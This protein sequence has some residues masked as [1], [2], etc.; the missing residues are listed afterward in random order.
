MLT[1]RGTIN[2]TSGARF[3]D[4]V[5]R[6]GTLY[7]AT[8]QPKYLAFN[9][10]T[11]QLMASS[12][13][14]VS[15]SGIALVNAASA[16]VTSST[17]S[18]VDRVELATGYRTQV[19]T[20]ASTTVSNTISQQVAAQG[21][22]AISTRSTTG[23]VQ[24]IDASTAGMTVSSVAVA[25]LTGQT[26]RCV[27]PK[28]G[29]SNFFIGTSDGKIHE[30]NDTGF[31]FRTI[32]FPNTPNV[33]TPTFHVGSLSYYDPYI[34]ATTTHGAA[35]LYNLSASSIQ[36]VQMVGT[37]DSSNVTCPLSQNASGMCLMGRALAPGNSY[38]DVT[39]VL[40][41]KGY[42]TFP[43]TFFNEINV[44]YNNVGL[45]I[46]TSIC[47]IQAN[48]TTGNYQLRTFDLI[49]NN[50]IQV[51]TA[52]QKPQGTYVGG[53][54]IRIRDDGIGRTVVELDQAIGAAP[55]LLPAAEGHNY[56]EIS[57]TSD[58]ELDVRQFLA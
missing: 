26:A 53:N 30:I 50:K 23:T 44:A 6:D 49:P 20:G 37:A 33:S 21:T 12:T 34:L 27:I 10:S 13:T 18:A 45:D 51:E 36:S 19:T 31:T 22:T 32:T 15:P 11:L 28:T 48:T 57:R 24:K 58:P 25:A 46:N 1:L 55:V 54:I 52:I 38:A 40:F 47:W 39:E 5:S 3:V 4:A 2:D 16:V 17:S 43:S 29:T 35:Y 56:I 7:V 8:T 42:I 41:E 9:L 14:L